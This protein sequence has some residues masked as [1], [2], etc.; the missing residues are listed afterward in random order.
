MGVAA[1][2]VFAEFVR[3][4]LGRSRAL[5][6]ACVLTVNVSACFYSR[7][8]RGYAMLLL[9]IS[10]AWLSFERCLHDGRRR[11]FVFWAVL[12]VAAMY[13]HMFS[14]LVLAGQLLAAPFAAEFRQRLQS[15]AR[16]FLWISIGYF[17]MAIMIYYSH[18]QQIQWIQP[19]TSKTSS[20]FFLE[21][22]GN[23]PS[24]LA[25]SVILFVTT[26]VL[27]L[28]AIV[29]R[30]TSEERFGLAVAVIGTIVPVT[31]LALL[32]IVQPAFIA[33]YATQMVP[34]FALSCA[35][36]LSALPSRSSIAAVVVFGALSLVAFRNLDLNPPPYEQRNDFRSAVSYITAHAQP[37]DVIATWGPQARYGVEYYAR[38]LNAKPFPSFVFPGTNDTPAEAEFGWLPSVQYLD[39]VSA[40]NRRIWFLLD[41]NA[42]D[43][44]LGIV[45]HFFRRR[46]GLGHHLVSQTQHGYAQLSEFA[47][48]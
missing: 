13:V 26:C 42:P 44:D 29:R 48:E 41:R 11:W 20:K 32:S 10:L 33:R 19:I 28:I 39:S 31:L 3:R 4:I 38:R 8:I 1:I 35:L 24:L 22:T 34:T 6:A 27:F 14:V 21:F 45:P 17:P 23:S 15:F 12:W 30:K 7:E 5:L 2:G 16:A 18:R 37:G 9:L 25:V 43:K 40:G 36:A 47:T 46:F